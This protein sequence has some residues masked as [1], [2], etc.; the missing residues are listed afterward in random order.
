MNF[1]FGPY[2][3]DL[4]RQDLQGPEGP[5]EGEPQ[6]FA[7]LTF[8]AENAD[9]VVLNDEI[10]EAVWDGHIVSDASLNTRINTARREVGD[11]GHRQ[12]VIRTCPRRRFRFV[13]VVE[14]ASAETAP[15]A[16]DRG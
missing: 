12:E 14:G 7:L 11:D 2:T 16:I 5:V 15:G 1:R 9:R 6:V 13:A 10:F 3:L 8:L 4:D